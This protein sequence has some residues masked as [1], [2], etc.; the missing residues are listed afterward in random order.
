MGIQ[1]VFADQ[2]VL[3]GIF[4]SLVKI[5]HGKTL[6]LS[7]SHLVSTERGQG[8][9]WTIFMVPM[10]LDAAISPRGMDS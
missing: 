1:L 3:I 7:E 2:L 10:V 8:V 9:S 6:L 4:S 5:Y